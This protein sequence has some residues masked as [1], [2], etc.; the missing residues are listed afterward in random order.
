MDKDYVINIEGLEI[1]ID[2]EK[3]NDIAERFR[4]V[5]SYAGMNRKAFAAW[6]H[7]PYNTMCDWESG[8][9]KMPEYVFELIAYKV[10]NEKRNG[11]I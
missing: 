4:L 8:E 10:M 7:I 3:R 5:R 2:E 1:V 6:L 9:R 11:R